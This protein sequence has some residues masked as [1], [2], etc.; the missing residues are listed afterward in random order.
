[1]LYKNK[2]ADMW[3][4]YLAAS[5]TFTKHTEGDDK[6]KY[7]LSLQSDKNDYRH[8]WRTIDSEWVNRN[9]DGTLIIE[10]GDRWMSVTIP[11]GP[12]LHG[13]DLPVT[14]GSKLFMTLY[15]NP[16]KDY[17][18]G[19]L[20]LKDVSAQWVEPSGMTKLSRWNYL[21]VQ[22]FDPEQYLRDLMDELK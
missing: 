14:D 7:L 6:G 5:I 22:E 16:E 12:A 2:V 20:V 19:K 15:A 9:W 1:M 10:T 8:W 17:S 3:R 11:G 4:S 13:V 21:D 18:T